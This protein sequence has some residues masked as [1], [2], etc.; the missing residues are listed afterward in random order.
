MDSMTSPQG[1]QHDDHCAAKELHEWV[2][3]P[4]TTDVEAKLAVNKGLLDGT[5]SLSA[6]PRYVVSKSD[7][8]E[9]LYWSPKGWTTLALA[10]RYGHDTV[11]ATPEPKNEGFWMDEARAQEL[12]E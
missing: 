1:Q 3:W 11:T 4:A 12:E 7:S 6:E 9:H 5:I 8:V 2:D 10:T